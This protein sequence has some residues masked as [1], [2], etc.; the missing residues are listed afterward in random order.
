ML[1][2]HWLGR[3]ANRDNILV[4]DAALAAAGVSVEQIE[5]GGDV[6][7]HGPGQLMIYPEVRLRSGVV[8]FLVRVAD[9]IAQACAALGA[10]GGGWQR[11]PAG[12]WKD[13]AK[14]AACGIHVARG[15]ATSSAKRG[16]GSGRAG[17]RCRRS[18]SRRCAGPRSTSPRSLPRSDHAW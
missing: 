6:T 3:S 8:D 18:R 11:E 14:L 13:G 17:S 5:R 2:W 12:V 16:R 4:D 10:P 1:A 9:A 7:Y 15:V